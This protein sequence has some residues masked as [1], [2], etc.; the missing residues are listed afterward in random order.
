M[1]EWQQIFLFFLARVSQTFEKKKR[2]RYTPPDEFKT[3]DDK[4]KERLVVSTLVI[5]RVTL[6]DMD[7]YQCVA[8]NAI[9]SV[10]KTLQ[11]KCKKVTA[12]EYKSFWVFA[13]RGI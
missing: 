12:E 8:T 7:S 5:N 4:I 11:V 10:N 2:A 1:T 9:D 3:S 13:G 6:D